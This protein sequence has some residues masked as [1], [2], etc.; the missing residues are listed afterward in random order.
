[1]DMTHMTPF[2]HA[3]DGG[4]V[5]RL[6]EHLSDDVVLNSPLLPDP[7]TGKEKVMGLLKVLRSAIDTFETTGIIAEERRAAVI[8][9]IRA[10]EAE[11]TGVDLMTVDAHG[12]IDGMTIQWRPLGA[13]VAIQQK[14]APLIGIPALELV[15]K[16][17]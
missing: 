5:D 8:I 2:L 13:S 16:A 10:G 17:A 9:R 4:S 7:F 11:V 1:M 14:L 15:A 6:A 12:L 3:L